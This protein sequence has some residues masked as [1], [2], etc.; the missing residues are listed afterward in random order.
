MTLSES[1][2]ENR[3]KNLLQ[4]MPG[5]S[6]YEPTDYHWTDRLQAQLTEELI[7]CS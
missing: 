1:A 4:C 6:I 3:S 5:S 7:V 2:L